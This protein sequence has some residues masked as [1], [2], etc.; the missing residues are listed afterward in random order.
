MVQDYNMR[1]AQQTGFV[2]EALMNAE[3][4]GYDDEAEASAAGEPRAPAPSTAGAGTNRWAA[5][6]VCEKQ[7]AGGRG[8]GDRC[9]RRV[10]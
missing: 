6:L 1:R 5:F 7:G 10:T 9:G 3:E 4:D 2:A 8:R